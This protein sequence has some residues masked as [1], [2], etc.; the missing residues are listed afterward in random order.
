MNGLIMRVNWVGR[1][2]LPI[3]VFLGA[4]LA[5]LAH[6]DGGTGVSDSGTVKGFAFNNGATNTSWYYSTRDSDLDSVVTVPRSMAQTSSLPEMRALG[7]SELQLDY[8]LRNTQIHL[9]NVK[10]D[11]SNL[12]QIGF[13]RDSVRFDA[14]G[15][16]GE[17]V[18]GLRSRYSGIDPFLFH[19][20]V[21]QD[22]Q[23]SGL[24]MGYQMGKAGTLNLAQATITSRGLE[25]RLVQR[26]GYTRGAVEMSY[27]RVRRGAQSVGSAYAISA[28]LGKFRFGYD[29]LSHDNGSRFQS[30]T[31]ITRVKGVRYSASL[32]SAQ[33]PLYSRKN[34]N[35][36]MFSV[37]F[38]TKGGSRWLNN[39]ETSAEAQQ[40]GG[41]E[42]DQQGGSNGNKYLIGGALVGAGLAI[43]SGSS[44]S[45]NAQRFTAQ[46][47]AAY[48]V[49]NRIN[50][51]S[52]AEN[53]EYGGY[54]Y[55]NPDGS[56]SSTAPVKGTPN[57]VLLPPISSVIPASS[58]VRASYHTHA[59]PDPRYDNENFSPVDIA[60]DIEFGLDGY[61]GT[62]GGLFRFH[63]LSAGTI[64]TLGTIAN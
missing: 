46:D 16:N 58:R 48:Y 22:Y 2:L 9:A 6:S 3:I 21:E 5:G 36:L 17:T 14:F 4:A 34:E 32:Q 60:A 28:G 40:E 38:S 19:G 49:L 61:L 30:A 54:V 52:V 26:L 33:N 18:A 63:D 12:L 55:R 23:Y 37:G 43:S 42:S 35:R 10:S 59:G 20:G 56:F 1:V 50:P 25:D 45:D 39:A 11:S 53:R 57:S 13:S 7:F 47:G 51:R 31:L 44:S 27:A 29:H 64:T 62:P 15:G 41:E 8:S 24:A